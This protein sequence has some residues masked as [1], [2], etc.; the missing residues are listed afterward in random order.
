MKLAVYWTGSCGGCDVAFLELGPA[1]LDLLPKLEIVFWPALVDAKRAD[2]EKLPKHGIDVALVNGVLRTTENVEMA[3]LLR[4]KSRWL[5]AFGACAHLGGVPA[6]ANP[7]EGIAEVVFGPG[8]RPAPPLGEAP[9]DAPPELLPEA[10]PLEEVVPVD[11]V[12]PG[13]PPPAGLIA[14]FFAVALAEEIQPGQVFAAEKALCEECPRTREER[15]LARLVRP[16][17]A[18]ADPTKCLLDQGMVCLGPVT[19]GGCAAACPK[20]GMPCT[21]CLGP[22]PKAGDPALAM[23]SALASLVR[24]GEEGEPAFPEEDRILE[25]LV[26]PLG[27]L[28]KY[29]FAKYGRPL[30][31]LARRRQEV[32]A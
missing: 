24:A 13:C 5:G 15:R 19:R 29:A 27:T 28:Y 9:E 6:L 2:L 7:G 14:R 25:G 17:E 11:F 8:F 32:R 10:L 22:T 12:V 31:R 30:R 16:H 4:E 23:L 20:A 18:L 21:G 26:D 3:E 1:L